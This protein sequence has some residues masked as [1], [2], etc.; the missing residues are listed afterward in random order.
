M[1]VN[2]DPHHRQ[3]GWLDLDLEKL[4]IRDGAAFQVHDQLSDARYLWSGSRNY[5]DLDPASLPAH[6]FVLRY[7]VRSESDFDYFA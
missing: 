1:V 3:A 7:R 6:L 5:V 4:G 2:L